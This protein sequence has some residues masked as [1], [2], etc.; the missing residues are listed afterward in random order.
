MQSGNEFTVD[1]L[2]GVFFLHSGIKVKIPKG[3]VTGSK[4]IKLDTISSDSVNTL[5]PISNF[6]YCNFISGISIA[7]DT[8]NFRKP[9]KIKIPLNNIEESSL[10]MLYEVQSESNTWQ[11][12]DETMIVSP[13]D[14]FIE[15]I[16]ANAGH[17]NNL[18][19][20]GS[21]I[22]K[23]VIEFFI[24]AYEFIVWGNDPCKRKDPIVIKTIDVDYE[25]SGGCIVGHTEQEVI[26]YGC[27]PPQKEPFR[28]TEISYSCVPELIISTKS[29]KIEKDECSSIMLKTSIGKLPLTDQ[30]INLNASGNL[31]VNRTV[32]KTDSNGN[33]SFSI[34]GIEIGIGTVYLSVSFEYYLTTIYAESNGQTYKN[35]FDTVKIKQYHSISVTVYD[36]PTVSTDYPKEIKCTSATIGGNV[37]ND[38]YDPVTTRGVEINGTKL[39]VGS[40]TGS[41]SVNISNLTPDTPYSVK[42]YATNIAGT[43]YGAPVSFTTADVDKN[44][45]VTSALTESTCTSVN[46]ESTINYVGDKDQLIHERGIYYGQDPNPELTGTKVKS[47]YGT[48]KFT[49]SLKDLEPETTYFFKGYAIAGFPGEICGTVYG[50]QVSFKGQDLLGTVWDRDGNAYST[51]RIGTQVWMAE[52]LRTTSQLYYIPDDSTWYSNW[53]YS[54]YT[55]DAKI[56]AYCWYD[57]NMQYK[58][59]YGA[60]YNG[61]AVRKGNLCPTGWHVPSID[62]WSILIDSLGGNLI[63]GRKL[64]ETDTIHWESPNTNATNEVC[65]NALPGGMRGLSGGLYPSFCY[66]RR[67]ASWWSSTIEDS[68]I[69]DINLT[70]DIFRGDNREDLLFSPSDC[71]QACSVRCIKD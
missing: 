21:G 47:G 28:T 45:S 30:L 22:F 20:G 54:H 25:N 60:L 42:A 58:Y 66:L 49:F 15:I 51:V 44:I 34:C 9:I 48:G 57:N 18:I 4:V 27:D 39:S 50:N 35:V 62:D 23:D 38:N 6:A 31:Y 71:W 17:T 67:N 14:K 36:K 41:F 55:D 70:Y 12:S 40:G 24:T 29:L 2:G 37:I 5:A 13:E 7:T 43:G 53:F 68:R 33:E 19:K 65:F 59:T 3:A 11:L 1:S 32:L 56:P 26:F 52:N 10:P 64:R 63:A 46:L 61:Y 69:S 8:L 16:L